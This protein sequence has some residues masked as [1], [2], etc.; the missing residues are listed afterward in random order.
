LKQFKEKLDE[1]MNIIKDL[2]EKR[3]NRTSEN[4]DTESK[5]KKTRKSKKN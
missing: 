3:E 1:T 4:Q 5:P 2:D